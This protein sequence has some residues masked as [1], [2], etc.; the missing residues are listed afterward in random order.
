M[1]VRT[2][3]KRVD[4]IES[5][6]KGSHDKHNIEI[7]RGKFKALHEVNNDDSPAF[8][9]GLED[10]LAWFKESD[11]EWSA[12]IVREFLEALPEE[13]RQ[14]VITELEKRGETQKSGQMYPDA[15]DL[16]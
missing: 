10:V 5:Q 1:N 11:T 8:A 7:M 3:Q 9:R 4:G 12:E 16:G 14:G 13:L 2:L 6:V 15:R